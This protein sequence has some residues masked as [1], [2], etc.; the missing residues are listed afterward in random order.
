VADV[1]PSALFSRQPLVGA[2]PFGRRRLGTGRG[3]GLEGKLGFFKRLSGKVVGPDLEPVIL[4]GGESVEVVGDSY[5]Q[6][7]LDAIC[8]GK[9]EDGH[10]LMC[11]AELRPEPDNEYDK[12][13]V[14]VYVDGRK[15]GHLNRADANAGLPRVRLTVVV[16]DH[17]A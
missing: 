4:P 1:W 6:D 3:A 10:Q 8:G 13:A 9:C 14:G 15:V 11:R 7:A 16:T 2:I 12:R 5:Y 17:A